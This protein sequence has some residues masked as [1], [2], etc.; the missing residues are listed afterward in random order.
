[1]EKE[2]KTSQKPRKKW[3]WIILFVFL[4][5]FVSF[6]F[7]PSLA[8]THLGKKILIYFVAKRT[9]AHLTIGKLKLTWFGPQEIYHLQYASKKM[10]ASFDEFFASI[11]LWKLFFLSK[12]ELKNLQ[13]NFQVK[14]GNIHL[15][16]P[17]YPETIISHLQ[18]AIE[19]KK[20]AQGFTSINLSAEVS[21]PQNKEEGYAEIVG[22]VSR[23]PNKENFSF[24]NFYCN[25][26][27]N[28]RNMPSFIWD[29][30]S[31]KK[32]FS[33][34]L[35]NKANISSYFILEKGKGPIHVDIAST[36]LKTQLNLFFDK[37]MLTSQ[38][39]LH[40]EFRLT[41]R[42]SCYLLQDINPFFLTGVEAKNPIY[43]TIP[44]ENFRF[45]LFPYDKKSISIQNAT[46]DMGK[47]LCKNGGTLALTISLL[48]MRSL[49]GIDQMEVWFTPVDFDV[50]DGVLISDRID[51][52][53][54][55]SL[56]LCSWG[57]MNLINDKINMV[58]GLTA[59]VL[60]RSF[61]IKNLSS[62]YVLQ[63]PIK[64]T[65]SDPKIN[66]SKGA[67]KIAALV[68]VQAGGDF[69]KIIGPLAVKEKKAPP[70]KYPLPWGGD[71]GSPEKED[72]WGPFQKFFN[73]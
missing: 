4:F 66:L 58:L 67:A 27:I 71:V 20:I 15:H 23:L 45:P 59:S 7:L 38:N 41:E 35:G 60:R 43:L 17:K 64:G 5:F 51:M 31:E 13:G 73:P 18:G 62:G 22:R 53:V 68:G 48:K 21:T 26:K 30:F 12:I 24:D 36:S 70:Q 57:D 34:L 56:H 44:K 16:T 33:A 1:M 54:A 65:K 47:I 3:R 19:R 46:L 39:P 11:T 55:N 8:S 50:R 2:E 49:F 14:N 69:G 10:D 42:L 6:L 63:I 9:D 29:F 52:L 61:G 72:S 25:L 37:G 28:I 40:M 32:S